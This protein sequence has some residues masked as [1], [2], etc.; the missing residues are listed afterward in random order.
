M[1]NG[2]SPGLDQGAPRL[3]G[4][5]FSLAIVRRLTQDGSRQLSYPL[6]NG[7]EL[8]TERIGTTYRSYLFELLSNIYVDERFEGPMG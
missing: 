4:G 2:V 5:R 7:K 8:S 1:K 3:A 6:S